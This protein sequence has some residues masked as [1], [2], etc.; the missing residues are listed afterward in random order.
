MAISNPRTAKGPGGEACDAKQELSSSEVAP[1][2]E[3]SLNRGS[4]ETRLRLRSD[5]EQSP[6]TVCRIGSG[7]T[8]QA[9]PSGPVGIARRESTAD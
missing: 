4:S 6:S 8:P 7:M 3:Y 5:N 1:S 9:V 2:G